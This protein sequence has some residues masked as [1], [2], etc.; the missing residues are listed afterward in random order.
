M[1]LLSE[2]AFVMANQTSQSRKLRLLPARWT[3]MS[4]SLKLMQTRQV[5]SC[6]AA[7]AMQHKCSHCKLYVHCVLQEFKDDAQASFSAR[8]EVVHPTDEQLRDLVADCDKLPV[9]AVSYV[10]TVLMSYSLVKRTACGTLFLRPCASEPLLPCL[11]TGYLYQGCSICNWSFPAL[12]TNP[13]FM[14]FC[15]ILGGRFGTTSCE[16]S[17][18]HSTQYFPG[19]SAGKSRE[20]AVKPGNDGENLGRVFGYAKCDSRTTVT[21]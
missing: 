1:L 6:A 4:R 2:A 17:L 10:C 11:G 5:W 18:Y 15:H 19:E 9:G 12:A 20:S 13:E 8:R 7:C 3:T 14:T 21:P 16:R